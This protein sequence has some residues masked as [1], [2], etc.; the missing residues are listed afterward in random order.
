[1]SY[2]SSNSTFLSLPSMRRTV[3]Q[4]GGMT[5][6][7]EYR[8]I[9]TIIEALGDNIPI[10][11]LTATATP[12]VQSDIIKN[13]SMEDTNIFISSFNRP[14]LYYE[15]RPKI[16]KT[17]A[18]KN[19]VQIIKGMPDKSGIIYVQSR[20]ATEEIASV[21]NVNDIK[22]APY[23]AGLDSK[24][25]VQRTG[26]FFNGRYRRHLCDDRIWNGN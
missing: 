10:I 22:A 9:R 12:K 5:S 17:N 2:S 8:R 6:E 19:I 3:Y 4:N 21:L 16:N 23:H 25:T 24:N 18:I 11:A 20:K 15:V 7:P 26:R 13:L 1:M 14:N